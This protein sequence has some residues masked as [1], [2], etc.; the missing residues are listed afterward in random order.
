M[1]RNH[2]LNLKVWMNLLCDELF[3]RKVTHFGI[4]I[5]AVAPI[6]CGT[7][8][9]FGFVNVNVASFKKEKNL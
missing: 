2:F 9:D 1:R 5:F 7:D 3:C 4:G 8:E 6:C